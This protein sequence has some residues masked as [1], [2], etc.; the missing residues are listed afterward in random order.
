MISFEL[1][2]LLIKNIYDCSVLS[3]LGSHAYFG[4]KKGKVIVVAITFS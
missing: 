2:C 1:F 4:R 3:L